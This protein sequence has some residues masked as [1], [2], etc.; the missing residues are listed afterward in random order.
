[1]SIRD[2][3]GNNIRYLAFTL[4]A[5]EESPPISLFVTAESLSSASFKALT[6]VATVMGKIEGEVGDYQNLETNPLNLSGFVGVEK[7]IKI[8][9]YA[10]YIIPGYGI[11]RINLGMLS[12][13]PANWLA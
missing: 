12:G 5:G 8:K 9:V 11:F 10:P 2:G 6:A 3:S 13:S 4:A 1:M 7:E